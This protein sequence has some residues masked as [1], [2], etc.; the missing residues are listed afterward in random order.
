MAFADDML[1][2]VIT[3]KSVRALEVFSQLQS[4]VE[5]VGLMVNRNKNLHMKTSGNVEKYSL[6][7]LLVGEGECKDTKEFKYLGVL[8]KNNDASHQEM[9]ARLA[10]G[11]ESLFCTAEPYQIKALILRSQG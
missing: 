11:T 9:R 10:A 8:L 4:A 2:V 6:F 1:Y 7:F 5:E 3:A